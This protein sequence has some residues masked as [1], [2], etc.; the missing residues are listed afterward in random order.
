[1]E[2]G[3]AQ[4]YQFGVDSSVVLILPFSAV[5]ACAT[6]VWAAATGHVRL[7]LIWPFAFST[8]CAAAVFVGLP[9]PSSALLWVAMLFVVAMWVAFGTIV[10]ALF[11]KLLGRLLRIR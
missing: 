4:H 6:L 5:V 9:A 8:L 3:H 7:R 1:M 10:G 2:S 11:G